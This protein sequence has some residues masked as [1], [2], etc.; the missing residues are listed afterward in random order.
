MQAL[1]YL[2]LIVDLRELYMVGQELESIILY[3]KDAAV[4]LC[5]PL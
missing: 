4:E 1:V 5:S 3:G 2:G